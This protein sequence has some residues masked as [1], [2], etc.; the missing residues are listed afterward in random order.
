MFIPELLHIVSYK[1]HNLRIENIVDS[2]VVDNCYFKV[3]NTINL[4]FNEEH[5]LVKAMLEI[6]ID[7]LSETDDSLQAKSNIVIE[8]VFEVDNFSDLHKINEE[9]LFVVNKIL[10]TNIAA[11]A[12]STTRGLLLD[13]FRDSAFD[14]FVLPIIDVNKDI[15]TNSQS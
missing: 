13:K 6:S 9:G 8:F 12:Y 11:I 4:G 2:E 1:L 15:I 10:T 14:E 7:K 5:S 3:D